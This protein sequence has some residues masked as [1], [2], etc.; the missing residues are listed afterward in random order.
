MES[1]FSG[2]RRM[3]ISLVLFAAFASAAAASGL[4]KITG[5]SASDDGAMIRFENGLMKL[6]GYGDGIVR[7]RVTDRDKFEPD[8]SFALAPDAPRPGALKLTEDAEGVVFETGLLKGRVSRENGRLSIWDSTGLLLL[9]EP[10]SGGAS[11]DNGRPSVTRLLPLDEHYYGFGEKT[12]P[13]DKRGY[14]MTMWNTD[15]TYTTRADPLYQSHPYYLALRKG[16]AYGIFQDNTFKSMF[17]VGAGDP[18]LLKYNAEGGELNYYFIY[19]P[20]PKQV[21]ERYGSLVGRFPLPPLWALGNMQCRWSYKN[22]RQLREIASKFRTNNVPCDVLFLDIHYMEHY[23]VFTFNRDRFPDPAGLFGELEKQGFKIIPIIDPG[24]KIE[25]G[26]HVYEQ[27]LAG[28]YFIRNPKGENFKANVWPGPCY[29][30]DFSRPEVREWW[31]GLYKVL[32]D[33]G[34]DGI[35]NDMNEIAAWARDLRVGQFMIPIPGT[36]NFNNMVQG[37]R[38]NPAPHA[39]MRNVYALQESEAAYNGLLK[40]RPNQRPLLISRAGYPG[41]QRYSSM[42]TGDNTASWPQLRMALPM[43]LNLGISGQ[44]MTGSDIG[45]FVGAPT[46]E[47]YA[48]WIEQGAFY[49]LCRTHTMQLTPSQDPFSYGKEVQRISKSVIDLRYRLLPYSYGYFKQAA[50]TGLPIMRAMI[51]EFPADEKVYEDSSQFMW[52][53]Y[54]LVAPVLEDKARSREIYLPEGKWYRF[55]SSASVDGGKTI[56]EK[57]DLASLPIFAREGAVIPLAPAMNY[58]SEKPWSPITVEFY[59]GGRKSCFTLYE[60]DGGSLDYLKGGYLKTGYC[61]EPVENGLKLGK[62][63]GEGDWRPGTR[64]AIYKLFGAQKPSSVKIGADNVAYSFDAPGRT[65]EIRLK[66]SAQPFELEIVY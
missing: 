29:F 38:D 62:S 44:V 3:L 64:E 1:R 35:W 6:S 34:I 42:W 24:V 52:G 57:V 50:E 28:D 45:G 16:K 27:G 54:L 66:D 22:E 39:R 21:I 43:N 23:K 33:A 36:V 31:G 7:V 5:V 2:M 56:T 30:P 4:G 40:I 58:T 26:Y 51:L 32:I 55:E 11:F 48:R 61:Q 53:E 46:P 15:N 18:G 47:L 9:E 20:S 59:A 65:L 41:L 19:G 12:G 60:D 14:K 13:L 37:P 17:D 10:K 8:L 63:A 49:P 25:K